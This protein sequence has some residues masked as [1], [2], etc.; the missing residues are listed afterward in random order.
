MAT[1]KPGPN[2]AAYWLVKNKTTGHSLVSYGTAPTSAAIV[3]AL[4]A[5]NAGELAPYGWT[6]NFLQGLEA[7]MGK[8]E[9]SIDTFPTGFKPNKGTDIMPLNFDLLT[10]A[11]VNKNAYQQATSAAGGFI[12]NLVSSDWEKFAVRALGALAGIALILLGLQALTGTGD[13]NPVTAARKV[14]ARIL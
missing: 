3:K 11:G 1:G 5:K 13:G 14:G 6:G 4:G 7:G 12:D 8:L 2:Q 10:P 9:L